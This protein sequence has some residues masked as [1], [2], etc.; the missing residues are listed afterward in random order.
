MNNLLKVT[1]VVLI[2]IITFSCTITPSNKDANWYSKQEN[3][4]LPAAIVFREGLRKYGVWAQVMTTDNYEMDSGKPFGHAVC[5][6]L[7]P[8]G[9]NTLWVY[10]FSGSTRVRAYTNNCVDIANK[11]WFWKAYRWECASA[12]YLK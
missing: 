12:E 4:C 7:Y 10:D 5:V 11:A 6:Y 8:P 3:A 2:S 1:A 9:K